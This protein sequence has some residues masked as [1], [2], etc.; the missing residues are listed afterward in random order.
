MNKQH[1]GLKI[2]LHSVLGSDLFLYF[3]VA[4]KGNLEE[5]RRLYYADI[6]RIKTQDNKGLTAAHKAAKFGRVN[7]LEFIANHNGG[8]VFQIFVFVSLFSIS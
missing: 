4:G 6:S 7:I 8:K 3:Q 2:K 1:C 5:F